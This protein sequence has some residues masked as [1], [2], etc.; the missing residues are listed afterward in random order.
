MSISGCGELAS[1]SL[2]SE[3]EC[4]SFLPIGR[5]NFSKEEKW[6]D[7]L[8]SGLKEKVVRILH[9]WSDVGLDEK[10]YEERKSILKRHLDTLLDNM[11]TEEERSVAD[12]RSIVSDM[13]V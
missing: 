7:S 2:P 11:I 1:R 3:D 12:L 5:V 10:P 13:G 6:I 9:L 4:S 8:L